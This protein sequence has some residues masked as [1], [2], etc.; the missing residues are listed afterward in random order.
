MCFQ[1]FLSSELPV[2]AGDVGV[3]FKVLPLMRPHVREDFK[4][5]IFFWPPVYKKNKK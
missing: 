5:H 1:A 4:T 2:K 3:F